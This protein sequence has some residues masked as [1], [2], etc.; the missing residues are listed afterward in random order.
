MKQT[1]LNSSRRKFLRRAGKFA[2]LAALSGIAPLPLAQLLPPAS[3][4]T[5][6]LRIRDVRA[7]PIYINVRSGIANDVSSFDV[8]QALV[9]ALV[10]VMIDKGLDLG[11]QSIGQT[12]ST[13]SL[14]CCNSSWDR[15]CSL[16]CEV[17]LLHVVSLADLH[18]DAIACR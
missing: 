12:R 15:A 8:A 2:T 10:V 7:Y 11:I 4:Q 14:A 3:A 18:S 1:N 6:S 5:G 9:V 17:L 16:R 13:S